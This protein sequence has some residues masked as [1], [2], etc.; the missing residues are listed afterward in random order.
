MSKI[1]LLTRGLKWYGFRNLD[2]ELAPEVSEDPAK[3]LEVNAY[4]NFMKGK[5]GNYKDNKIFRHPG[6]VFT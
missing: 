3:M 6:P 4:L 5:G 1:G 2:G